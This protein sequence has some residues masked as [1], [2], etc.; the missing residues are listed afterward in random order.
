MASTT[1][2]PTATP[3]VFGGALTILRARWRV[4][5]NTFWR[6]KLIRKLLLVVALIGL[7]ALSFGLYQLTRFIV[8]GLQ[9][10]S[11][12]PEA[13]EI[14]AQLGSID[15]LF[16]AVPSIA[17]GLF[18]LPLLL[19]SVSFALSTL[20]LA[21]DLDTL[22]VTPVPVRSVF[23]ARFLEGLSTPYLLLFVLL[24]PALI[25]YGQ[26]L[27]YSFGYYVVLIVVLL[28]L[29]LL[30]RG[31][32]ALLTMLLV[33]IIPPRR[34]RDVFAVIGGLFGLVIY[35]GSQMLNRVAV[36]IATPQNAERLLRFDLGI[37]PTSWGARA[38]TAAGTGDVATLLIYGLLYAAATLGFF[39]VCVL[40]AE[41]LYASGLISIAG[42]ESGRVRR[43]V[44]AEGVGREPLLRGPIGAILH[45][46]LRI[47]PRDLQQLSQLIFPIA[48]AAFWI[49]QLLSDNDLRRVPFG[50]GR[51]FT[52][53]SLV[54][55]VMF[56]CMI[57]SGNLGLTGTSREGRS[58]WLLHIAPVD[59]WSTLWAKWALAFLP[60]P[61]IG[62]IAIGLVG[63]IQRQA[64]LLLIQNWL[65]LLL[66]GAG[67]AG[68]SVGL[69]A[70]FPRFDWENPR[71]MNSA[72]AGCLGPVLYLIYAGLAF[73]LVAVVRVIGADW[74]WWITALGW[75]GA[76]LLTA[77]AIWLPLLLAAERMRRIEI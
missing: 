23:L 14:I 49:W 63:V 65:L 71:K 77:L 16:A 4:A 34:L 47:I 31:V 3:S 43:R 53:I 59:P 72:R 32:G 45:K 6:G 58:Y 39:A 24:A 68:I 35:I 37:V 26:A 5:R 19:S 36:N 2:S 74:A 22:L 56:I 20:Y 62:T 9:Q 25:G 69:G 46:D 42:T 54:A 18:A 67:V 27:S 12:L 1:F 8:S 75:A 48:I 76:A 17:L 29:P 30:P 11:R 60:F 38:L 52:S 33:R 55:T 57:I 44:R 73:A 66:I 21:H 13:Q 50:A 41:R 64:P 15:R 51:E 70:A 28:L 10:F 61:I 7:G 40:L